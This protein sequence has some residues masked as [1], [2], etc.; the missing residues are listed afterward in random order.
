MK[1]RLVR[2]QQIWGS[3][4]I[5]WPAIGTA[6]RDFFVVLKRDNTWDDVD[7]N[8]R[9]KAYDNDIFLGPIELGGKI[10]YIDLIWVARTVAVSTT[11]ASD[12]GG[13]AY[14]S[15][16]GKLDYSGIVDTD[17]NVLTHPIEDSA[18]DWTTGNI[19][20]GAMQDRLAVIGDNSSTIGLAGT[21]VPVDVSGTVSWPFS[22][23]QNAVGDRVCKVWS[24]GR[25]CA[26]T[27]A[28]GAPLSPDTGVDFNV[29]GYDKIWPTLEFQN[30]NTLT[31]AKPTSISF[32]AKLIAN[33]YEAD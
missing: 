21:V 23:T 24:I 33:L 1:R 19:C 31:D 12:Q 29:S 32:A 4:S 28:A 9:A 11:D 22:G 17:S 20:V 16:I 10:D 5:A 8:G 15:A 2:S 6:K 7:D 3:D 27:N 14:L 25:A 13:K 26:S 30:P 18:V